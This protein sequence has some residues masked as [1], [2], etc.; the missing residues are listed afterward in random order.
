MLS[1]MIFA[2]ECAG[3]CGL[4]GTGRVVVVFEVLSTGIE[5][6]AENASDASILTRTL[7]STSAMP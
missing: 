6:A 7:G 4:F 1:E 5:L 3:E 2:E